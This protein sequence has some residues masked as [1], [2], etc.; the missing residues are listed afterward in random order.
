MLFLLITGQIYFYKSLVDFN[1]R[2]LNLELAIKEQIKASKSFQKKTEQRIA[3]LT[4]TMATNFKENFKQTGFIS[5]EKKLD[6]KTG[7][8][9]NKSWHRNGQLYRLEKYFPTGAIKDFYSIKDEGNATGFRLL[10]SED[11][12]EHLFYEKI[13][14]GKSFETAFYKFRAPHTGQDLKS[15]IYKGEIEWHKIEKDGRETVFFHDGSIQSIKHYKK[16]RKEGECRIFYPNGKIKA[17]SNWKQ[18]KI[19]GLQQFFFPSG[20]LRYEELISKG[21]LIS[22]K[23]FSAKNKP[24]ANIKNGTGKKMVYSEKDGLLLMEVGYKDFK[25]HGTRKIYY[26]NGAKKAFTDYRNGVQEG[27]DI[28]RFAGGNIASKILWKNGRASVSAQS[29]SNSE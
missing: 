23:Y 24:V 10:F 19:E 3:D 12:K 4:E 25:M 16:G 5:V 29:A 6:P 1:E 17:V 2:V 22:G 9:I 7:A 13:K 11:L 21:Q 28:S 20:K 27:W 8:L 15:I 18:G 26:A 14:K